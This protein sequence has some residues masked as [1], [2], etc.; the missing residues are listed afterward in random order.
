VAKA[1]HPELISRKVNDLK[2]AIDQNAHFLI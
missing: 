2:N 1:N